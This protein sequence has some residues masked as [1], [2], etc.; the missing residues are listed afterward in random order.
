MSQQLGKMAMSLSRKAVPNNHIVTEH[1]NV[2]KVLVRNPNHGVENPGRA[3]LAKVPPYNGYTAATFSANPISFRLTRG[4]FP[5]V[6]KSLTLEIAVTETG[7]AQ[8]CTPQIA[9]YLIDN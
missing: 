9:P 1:K 3:R 8:A 7:G 4:L 2:G 6:I 5:G